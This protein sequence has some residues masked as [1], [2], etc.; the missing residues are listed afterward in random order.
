MNLIKLLAI[1]LQRTFKSLC[2]KHVTIRLNGCYVQY[3][4]CNMLLRDIV[5]CRGCGECDD[6][7]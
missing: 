4:Q 3:V 5:T 1:R 7:Y 6:R 2:I